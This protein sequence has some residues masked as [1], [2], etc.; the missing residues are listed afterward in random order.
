I[1]G[2]MAR[3]VPPLRVFLV[4]LLVFMLVAEHKTEEMRHMAS[5]MPATLD[6]DAVANNAPAPDKPGEKLTTH[7]TPSLTVTT[8]R[9]ADGSV[10]RNVTRNIQVFTMSDA[11]AHFLADN[12]K[13]SEL[14]AWF[15]DD[16]YKALINPEAFFR[17]MFTWGHRLAL[18]GLPIVGLCLGLLYAGRRP[19]RRLWPCG[20]WRPFS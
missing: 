20:P 16:L 17:S 7:P 13:K 12:V 14:P 10:Q 1:E 4:S 18:L 19:G 11:D 5:H 6:L 15:R 8:E 2:R 3:H 9:M